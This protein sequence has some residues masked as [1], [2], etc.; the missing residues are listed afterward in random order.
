MPARVAMDTEISRNAAIQRGI[1]P[2]L[3]RFISGLKS[4]AK[5]MASRIGRI[6]SLAK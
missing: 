2:P 3:R 1:Q 5:K 6:S 4:S